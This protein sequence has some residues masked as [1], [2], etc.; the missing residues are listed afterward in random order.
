MRTG[1]GLVQRTVTL[2]SGCRL[3]WGNEINDRLI[4]NHTT[5]DT[6]IRGDP[7]QI[8]HILTAEQHLGEANNLK[9]TGFG[10]ATGAVWQIFRDHVPLW[11]S[12]KIQT[13]GI[14]PIQKEKSRVKKYAPETTPNIY[15]EENVAEYEKRMLELLTSFPTDD[16]EGQAAA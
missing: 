9:L 6:F 4:D 7:S 3:L 11:P 8:D 12:Y 13:G 1:M 15:K 5:L 2:Q 10:C 16:L 14:P